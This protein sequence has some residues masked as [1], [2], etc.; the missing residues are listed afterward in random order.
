MPTNHPDPTAPSPSTDRAD[1]AA[2]SPSNDRPGQAAPNN[3]ADLTA[4]GAPADHAPPD[5]HADHTPPNGTTHTRPATTAHPAH[6]VPPAPVRLHDV[7]R[8]HRTGAGET[9]TALDHVTLDFAAGTMTAVMGPSGSGKSTLLHCAAGLDRPTTGDV[10][11]AGT[12]TRDLDERALTH[13]RRDHV[14]FVFQALNLVSA[15]TA[16]Q[17]IALPLRLAGRRPDP[18]AVDRALRAV[19]LSDR[20]HHRPSRLSGGQQQRVA[21]ARALITGPAVLFAD[22]PT[23]ALDTT[24]SR[25]VLA[26]LRGLVD[27]HGQTV[28]MVTHDPAAASWA[29]RVVMLAD[30]RV[31]EDIPYRCAAETIA[32]RTAAAEVSA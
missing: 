13:L 4:P 29:D 11:L 14:G 15:L 22:E 19:G 30:G 32:A 8:L 9:V 25:V 17:N 12:P 1:S 5:S 23:G 20:A 24:T 10:T 3:G 2:P 16:A 7:T 18:A 31:I 27:D 6:V 28:V 21:I 26:L